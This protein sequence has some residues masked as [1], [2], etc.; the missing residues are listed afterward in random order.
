M[1]LFNEILKGIISELVPSSGKGHRRRIRIG[2]VF[3]AVGDEFYLSLKSDGNGKQTRTK[4]V[5][6]KVVRV[7]RKQQVVDG[8][9][10][11]WEL[12]Q[13]DSGKFVAVK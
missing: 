5:T 3:P 4:T 7:Y 1:S 6:R 11:V 12:G 10:D 8:A 9:G 13:L 2:N